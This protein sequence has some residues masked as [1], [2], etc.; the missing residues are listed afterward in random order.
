MNDFQTA[1][2]RRIALSNAQ[3]RQ[4]RLLYQKVADETAQRIKQ[5]EGRENVSSTLRRVYLNDLL[6]ETEKNIEALNQQ[7][8]SLVQSNMLAVSTA[9]VK[10]N[11]ILLRQMG[12]DLKQA[13][14]YVPKEVVEEVATGK[15]YKGRWTLSKAIWGD[16]KQ[17]MNE[18]HVVVA[19]GIAENKSAYDIAKDLERYVNPKARKDWSWSKVYPGTR[20]VIDYN[21]QRLARTMVSHAYEESFVRV[22][23]NNPFLEAYR[24]L[25]SNSDR[26]CPICI[27]RSED[28]Q[29]GLGAGVFP[30][31]ALPLD[32]P[33]GMCTFEAIRTK[34]YEQITDDLVAWAKGTGDSKLNEKLD[35]F[36]YDLLQRDGSIDEVKKSVKL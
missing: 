23:K 32:H 18:L 33:N 3:R 9:V 4:I 7:F 30:K 22:T 28:D 36:A 1:E 10:D 26:V 29:Y 24:W 34:S 19:K 8:E 2:G 14:L 21:A 17:V 13:Y 35:F 20:K 31:E 11:V 5:L 27:A 6:D 16:S 12:V 25:I 15:L